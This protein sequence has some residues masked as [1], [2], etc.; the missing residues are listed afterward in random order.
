M[1]PPAVAILYLFVQTIPGQI[2][3]AFIT[4]AD[5]VLYPSYLDAARVIDM[6]ALTDQQIGGLIMWIGT[7]TLYLAALGIIFFR[8]ANTEDREQQK[9]FARV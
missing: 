5:H 8:W 7:S 4:Y 1:I 2:V 9:R 3:G 6:S